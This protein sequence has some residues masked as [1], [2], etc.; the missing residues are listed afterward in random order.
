VSDFLVGVLPITGTGAATATATLATS[1][2]QRGYCLAAAV[3]VTAGTATLCRLELRSGATVIFAQ[4]FPVQAAAT[5]TGGAL[6]FP[7]LVPISAAGAALNIV[8]TT[9]GATT[10][11]VYGMVAYGP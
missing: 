11:N 2:S 4:T 9:T 6:I 7:M 1:A 5:A 10:T 8:A 3:E